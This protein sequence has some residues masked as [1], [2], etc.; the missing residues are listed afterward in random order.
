MTERSGSESATGETRQKSREVAAQGQE[1]A[2]E[3]AQQGREKAEGQIAVQ[4]ERAADQLEGVSRALRQT[5][6]QLRHENQ[7]SFGGYADRAAG[8]TER[9]SRFLHEKRGDELLGEVEDFARNK[10]AV[11]LGGAFAVG[12]A[13]ARF[14]KSSAGEREYFDVQGR[15]QELGAAAA[16]G[17]ASATGD[18]SGSSS[19]APEYRAP[20][21]SR[22]REEAERG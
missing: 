22:T 18:G 7:D 16:K 14:I 19:G 21:R 4:K 10:P 17:D 20:T 3:A 6:E 5:G 11:F 12:I 8:Q 2:Q 9:L 1:K 15:A 13:A